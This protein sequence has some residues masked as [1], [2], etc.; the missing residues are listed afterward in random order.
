MKGGRI[1][2]GYIVPDGYMGFINGTYVL[3]AT[4]NEYVEEW[5]SQNETKNQK[6][7][8]GEIQCAL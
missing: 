1:I 2:K 7:N 8:F 5:R 6:S 3:F 4:E